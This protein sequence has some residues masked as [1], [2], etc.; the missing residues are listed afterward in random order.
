MIRDSCIP[1]LSECF[2]GAI[3]A[4]EPWATKRADKFKP[5]V[6]AQKHPLKISAFKRLILSKLLANQLTLARSDAKAILNQPSKD[7]DMEVLFG[8]IPLCV[9]MGRNDIL[10]EVIETESGISSSVKAE[11]SRY[12]EEE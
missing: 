2:I 4:V 6:S 10:K 9:L 5:F 8:L 11:A 12:I 3:P 7:K 1:L